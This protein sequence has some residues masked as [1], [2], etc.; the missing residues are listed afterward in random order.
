MTEDDQAGG[1]ERG[2]RSGEIIQRL[3][4]TK[5]GSH[6]TTHLEISKHVLELFKKDSWQKGGRV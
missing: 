6:V 4:S 3:V 2:G 1:R 5:V